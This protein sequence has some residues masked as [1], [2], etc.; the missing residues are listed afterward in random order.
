MKRLDDTQVA[1]LKLAREE[2]GRAEPKLA[3][4]AG[5]LDKVLG[6]ETPA[7]EAP[8]SYGAAAESYARFAVR[9]GYSK[10]HVADLAKAGRIAT[11][12]EGR[13]ARV[14]VGESIEMLRGDGR[15]EPRPKDDEVEEAGRRWARRRSGLLRLVR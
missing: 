6:D 5:V 9:V 15:G 14:I 10:R 13:A 4:V 7:A 12:G 1:L 3:F 2:L 11:I 8:A